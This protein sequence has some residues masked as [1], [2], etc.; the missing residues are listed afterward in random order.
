M[1]L[2]PA[3][4]AEAYRECKRLR[5]L[6]Q[7][8]TSKAALRNPDDETPMEYTGSEATTPMEC[9]GSENDVVMMDFPEL[10]VV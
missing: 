5:D 6:D 9:T 2:T 7:S 4:G 1:L 3:E 10:S 8:S